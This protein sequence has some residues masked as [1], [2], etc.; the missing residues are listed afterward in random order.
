M[1][2]IQILQRESPLVVAREA[3]WR[4]RRNWN[5][6]RLSDRLGRL[7]SVEFRAL[8]YYNPDLRSM[9]KE[10]RAIIVSFADEILAGRYPFLG[11]GTVAL[12]K[13]PKW[14]VDF[15]SGDEWPSIPLET[16]QCIRF[17]RSDVKVPYEL[18]R[19]QFL[20]V[21]GKAHILTGRE[22]Y[23]QKAKDLLSHWI[24]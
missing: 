2:L 19:L 16:S 11:Y 14:N 3:F 10:G 8:P 13:H 20:P 12:G 24:E 6:K 23:R 7:P 18:S 9:S 17:D 15:T 4:A 1:R 22:T 21:L 5:R